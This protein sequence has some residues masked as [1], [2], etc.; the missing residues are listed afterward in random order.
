MLLLIRN[1][2]YAQKKLI[3]TSIADESNKFVQILKYTSYETSAYI[4]VRTS[5]KFAVNITISQ[6]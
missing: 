6:T 4:F 5:N 2:R 3:R 1:N